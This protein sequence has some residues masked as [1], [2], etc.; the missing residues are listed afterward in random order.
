MR[1]VLAPVVAPLA[2]LLM[3]AGPSAAP[4]AP[5]SNNV[6]GGSPRV[7]GGT[8]ATSTDAPWQ[9]LVLP[10]GH[11][12]G[13]AILDATHVV[14]AAH[15]V[16][17]EDDQAVIAPSA[18]TVHAG[19]TD[20]FEAGQHPTVAA[21]SVD[22]DYDP[23]QQTS[24]VAILTLATPLTFSGTV[25]AIA[26]TDVGYRPDQGDA[27]RLSGWGSEVARPPSDTTS[28]PHAV[29]DL[30]VATIFPS[31]ECATV[32]SPF[33]DSLLLC[34]GQAGTD[35]C[36]GDSGGPLAVQT[37]GVWQLAGIV[38]GGAGCAW[39]HYPG[40]Y[41]RVANPGIH[42]YLA[43]RGAGHTLQDPTV[44][45][46]PT[47]TGDAV[48]GGKLTCDVGTWQNAHSYEVAFVRGSTVIAYGS[49]M[50]VL[51]SHVGASITCVVE[52]YGLTGTAEATSSPVTVTA[53]PVPPRTIT[54]TLSAPN[55]AAVPS[56]DAAA[57]KVR[58]TKL[59]CARR[60]CTLDVRVDD[61]APSAGIEGV[62]ARVTTRY[63]AT[64]VKHHKRRRCTKSVKR[65][66][67]TVATGAGT[68]RVVTPKLHRGTQTFR[69]LATDR[70]GH[71]QAKATTVKK[72]TR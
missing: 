55:A 43:D 60:V 7:V 48:P 47:I 65:N 5:V 52:A 51:G 17:D 69:L 35:A 49:T 31:G 59:R 3:L 27:L 38:T 53:P 50:A 30:K 70:S 12:C 41:A 11:L 44:V 33:P 15:C 24:D 32:Y 2:L 10:E 72:A 18:V 37:G 63:R 6:V 25:Q 8:Q 14:T 46:P 56:P 4:A 26:L 62:E 22:P 45:S 68:Y 39:N 40:Y 42:G 28:T 20:R 67:R 34:A 64:C 66:L 71:R 61:P 19:I 16:F 1:R 29:D 54:V 13:G 9:A 23:E 36:Q 57:P 21:V 58:V